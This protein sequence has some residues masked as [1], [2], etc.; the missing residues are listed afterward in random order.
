LKVVRHRLEQGRW[1]RVHENVFAVAPVLGDDRAAVMAATLTAPGS[2]ASHAS[3][4]AVHGWWTLPRI[5][6]IVTRPGSGGPCRSDGVL[7]HRSETLEADTTR[8]DGIPV[9]TVP[10]ALLD[11]A[12]HISL[13][14]LRYCVRE[15]IRMETT[16]AAEII[17]ALTGPHR[18]RR[19][20]RR[21]TL[22]VAAFLGLPVHRA[23]SGSE[24]IALQILRDAGRP[25]P[26]LNAKVAGKEAD[27][28]WRDLKLII[29]VDGGPFHQDRG[30]DARKQAIWEGAGFTVIRVDSGELHEELLP[31]APNVED[32]AL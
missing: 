28:V 11:L 17:D 32:S 22:I 15:A 27:L 25:M 21:L 26:E 6:E 19:G 3:A 20:A 5:V 18:G 4:G 13:K 9:T 7:V 14:A 31:L 16:T 30:E 8:V 12:P 23:R 29:E 2:V 24:V 1:V 10:R